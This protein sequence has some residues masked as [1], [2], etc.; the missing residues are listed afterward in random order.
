MV[1]R[2][3]VIGTLIALVIVVVALLA[4]TTGFVN[5]DVLPLPDQSASGK[6]RFIDKAGVHYLSFEAPTLSADTRFYLPT[7]DG[8]PGQFLKTDGFG[9]FSFATGT[10]GTGCVVPGSD[11]DVVFND[12]GSCGADH[13]VFTFNKAT[14]TLF[15]PVIS[16]DNYLDVGTGN[17]VINGLDQL[18]A[19]SYTAGYGAYPG[20]SRGTYTFEGYNSAGTVVLIGDAGNRVGLTGA[21]DW[22]AQKADGT[23]GACADGVNGLSTSL[24]LTFTSNGFST[25]FRGNPLATATKLYNLP[26]KDGL[27]G[28]SLQTDGSTNLS[29]GNGGSGICG[30]DSY[31]IWNNMGGCGASGNLHWTNSTNTF[32]VQGQDVFQ[33]IAGLAV[34]HPTVVIAQ[35]ALETNNL[36]EVH[37]PNGT[38][39]LA[40]DNIGVLRPQAGVQITN[41]TSL[42]LFVKAGIG[43]VADLGEFV[44]SSNNVLVNINYL[45]TLLPQ[46]GAGITNGNNTELI[47]AAG[48]GQIGAGSQI[49]AQIDTSSSNHIETLASIGTNIYDKDF[50]DGTGAGG[51]GYHFAGGPAPGIGKDISLI[52]EI[53]T[54]PNG[55]GM[56]NAGV[57]TV[58]VACS[59]LSCAGG[60]AV[61][62]Q[63]NI[64][65][66]TQFGAN[67]TITIGGCTFQVKAGIVIN[68]GGG[69]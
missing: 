8:T 38:N 7:G 27:P 28:Q 1:A 68:I 22:C 9:H 16:G 18:L 17:T 40:I 42:E 53:T 56:V 10:G 5:L 37:A 59:G 55:L 41:G 23:F 39:W 24:K 48:V 21:G 34:G 47:I 45:G 32:F 46:R 65:P 20:Y 44:D 69:C 4:Q 58:A 14:Q 49:I 54:N 3:Y 12:G 57:V 43:Q 35:D 31:I 15:A 26:P 66:L 6:L 63:N 11:T 13:L 62:D 50:Y 61:Y 67:K 29:W 33:T 2:K 36:F 25:A 64:V 19:S 30:A 52:S 60:Y 51:I